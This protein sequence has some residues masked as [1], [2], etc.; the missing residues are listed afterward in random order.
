LGQLSIDDLAEEGVSI[1][2]DGDCPL[3][4]AYA[5]RQ[6]RVPGSG[7]ARLVNARKNP[8]LCRAL[9]ARGIDLNQGM[10]VAMDGTL[11]YGA[12]AVSVLA[13]RTR[14]HSRAAD[15]L[16]NRPLGK[17][18]VARMLYPVMKMVRRMTLRWLGKTP[19]Q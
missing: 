5:M 6:G 7:P 2:Y 9:A 15:F 8:I 1:V 4:R 10:V 17:P 14:G 16:I 18:W 19:I 13:Q 3:C 12:E 11:Y